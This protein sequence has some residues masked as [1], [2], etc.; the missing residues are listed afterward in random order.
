MQNIYDIVKDILFYTVI[1][2]LTRK[3]LLYRCRCAGIGKYYAIVLS[4]IY[5]VRCRCGVGHLKYYIGHGDSRLFLSQSM[6]HKPV[7]RN[8]NERP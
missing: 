2:V 5:Y 8:L 7:S 1:I 3:F 6:T 4:T